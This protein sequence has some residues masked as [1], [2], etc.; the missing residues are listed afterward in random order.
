MSESPTNPEQHDLQRLDRARPVGLQPQRRINPLAHYLLTLAAMIS[1]YSLY[2]MYVVPILEGP[3]GKIRKRIVARANTQTRQ[4]DKSWLQ[5]LL[6]ADGWEL[7]NCKTLVTSEGTILFQDYQPQ[8]DGYVDVF[9]FTLVMNAAPENTATDIAP[10]PTDKPPLVLRCL[11]GSRLKLN[12]PL[13]VGIGGGSLR[14]ESARLLGQVTVF[15]PESQQGVKDHI[16][17]WTSN[18]QIDRQQIFTLE[19]VRFQ[20]GGNEGEGRHLRIALDHRDGGTVG[21]QFDSVSGIRRLELATLQRL[22]IEPSHVSLSADSKAG[23]RREAPLSGQQSPL[24]L[25]CDGAFAFDFE[26]QIATFEDN[27]LV[28]EL[29]AQQNTLHCELLHLKFADR[30]SMPAVAVASA[31]DPGSRA[32]NERNDLQLV[33]LFAEGS[34]SAPV[35]IDSPERNTRIL[36]DRVDYQV[37]TRRIKASSRSQVAIDHPL[38]RITAK[39]LKYTLPP[40]GTPGPLDATGPGTLMRYATTDQEPLQLTWNGPLTMRLDNGQQVISIDGRTD[41]RMGAGTGIASDTMK[42]WLWQF[43]TTDVDNSSDWQWAPARLKAA[44][45]VDIQSPD[46]EGSTRRLTATWKNT[47]A[48]PAATTASAATANAWKWHRIDHNRSHP[49]ASTSRQRIQPPRFAS[50]VMPVAYESEIEPTTNRQF[51][52]RCDQIELALAQVEGSS[53]LEQLD[54]VENVE[55]VRQP[56]GL[57]AEPQQQPLVITGQRL[58]AIPT[59]GEFYRL[60]VTGTR[61][62]M[63]K[64][65]AEGLRLNGEAVF[66]DQDANKIWVEGA[67]DLELVASEGQPSR[68]LALSG[69]RAKSP[70]SV[71]VAWVG[72][73]IF[74]GTTIYFEHDVTMNAATTASGGTPSRSRSFSQGLSIALEHPVRF[75]DLSQESGQSSGQSKFEPSEMVL[76]DHLAADK[77][78]FQLASHQ[79]DSDD[80]SGDFASSK[81]NTPI[82]I[83][84]VS[85]DSFGQPAEMQ[86][87]IVP[88]AKFTVQSGAISA[89]GP[90]S[91]QL[92]RV[93]NNGLTESPVA[94]SPDRQGLVPRRVDPSKG[95][96]FVQINFDGPLLA[97]SIQKEMQIA[98]RVRSLTTPVASWDDTVNPDSDPSTWPSDAV[99]LICDRMQMAQWSPAGQ[100]E[101]TS[102]MIATGNAHIV[103]QIFE[104]TA[105]RVSY[106]QANDMLVVEG[107]PRTDAHLWYRQSAKASPDH[108]VAEKILYRLSDQWTEVQGVRNVNVKSK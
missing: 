31:E 39:E 23:I 103:S 19:Q 70:D 104:A 44:G 78:V 63:A 20:F 8:D 62:R 89:K 64:I 17:V 56:A 102:E 57:A 91:L 50:R 24:E 34:S 69:E 41:I 87:V 85:L 66:L 84:N 100:D 25:S 7:Q 86:K 29:D 15:R 37:A 11:Q 52:F 101:P 99:R 79:T 93:G 82:V 67:G 3:P 40:D 54:L 92:H 88:Q 60:T 43:Q 36:A 59:T 27:V 13:T 83:E 105:D 49:V 71:Q 38:G 10:E 75:D 96:T 12:R 18:V 72:G 68:K 4:Q 95:L 53:R 98:G 106:N 1:L 73:M 6:P 51:Q 81:R 94:R 80:G 55:V 14:M 48:T 28:Q 30:S 16:A 5:N 32:S 46:F 90:G 74:D 58:K 35:R 9:P 42:L 65:V 2:A 61:Q 97:N 45:N 26:T 21:S 108:L 47:T 107:T 77:R 22:H 33:S 76:V